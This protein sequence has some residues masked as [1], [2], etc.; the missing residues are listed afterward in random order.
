MKIIDKKILTPHLIYRKI[1]IPKK[2]LLDRDSAMMY[3]AC[4]VSLPLVN[5]YKR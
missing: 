1:L 5:G 4:K 3:N 2:G